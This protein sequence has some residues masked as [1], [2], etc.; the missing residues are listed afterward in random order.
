MKVT[1]KEFQFDRQKF[2]AVVHYIC[3]HCTP[4]ELGAVKLNKVLYYSDMLRYAA[5]GVPL[6]GEMYRKQQF[7]PVASHLPWALSDLQR[8]GAVRVREVN[9]FGYPKKEY[10]SEKAPDSTYLTVEEVE[11]INEFIDVVCG[12]SAK[13]ISELSHTAA[14]EL[15]DFGG[16][17][18]YHT[19]SRMFPVAMTDEDFEWAAQEVRKVVDSG[20]NAPAVSS[21]L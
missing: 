16:E 3:A 12:R 11:H 8:D 6:T 2:K 21:D 18:P 15:A 19:V 1:K 14:W 4:E 5:T 7:G 20:Q 17:I 13:E 10:V 9:Y